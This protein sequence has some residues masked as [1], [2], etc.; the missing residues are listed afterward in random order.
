MPR[1]NAP[2]IVGMLRTARLD[3]ILCHSALER[4]RRRAQDGGDPSLPPQNP[5]AEFPE[6]ARLKNG[7]KGTDFHF[8]P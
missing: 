8:P 2:R 7:S 6:R 5:A 1:R 4:R 3:R